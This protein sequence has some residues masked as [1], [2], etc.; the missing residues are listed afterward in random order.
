MAKKSGEAA[1]PSSTASSKSSS[2]LFDYYLVMDFEATCEDNVK[3]ADQEII[4]FPAVL[5]DAETKKIVSEFQR[6]VRP[7]RR[8]KLSAFCTAL[9]GIT[10]ETV[11]KANPFS[12]V[13]D[14]FMAWLLQGNLGEQSPSCSF[15]VVTCGD[16]DLK[17]MLP[18][19]F[20]LLGGLTASHANIP[21][22]FTKWVN[23]KHIFQRHMTQGKGR[24][25]KGMS[26]MLAMVGKQ[27][28]GRHHSGIDDC[29]NIAAALIG[30]MDTGVQVDY[31]WMGPAFGTKEGKSPT[32]FF[33]SH[34]TPPPISV[35]DSA[36][37]APLPALD[38][39]LSRPKKVTLGPLVQG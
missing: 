34:K 9:T 19:Q 30:C 5:V 12:H 8:P 13:Y 33:G 3:L 21:S 36:P 10:Q 6:Y 22:Y 37:L 11:E 18:L 25:P 20:S 31:T 2:T 38:A 26:E 15:A 29:R 39:D 16:W 4:E 23:L 35:V 7:V 17:T 32:R 28:V 27:V 14:E 1:T 24:G